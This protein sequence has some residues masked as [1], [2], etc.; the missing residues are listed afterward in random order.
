MKLLN[1]NKVVCLSPHPDDIEASMGGTIL[2]YQD[3]K[4]ISI[5]FST[6]SIHDPTSNEARWEEC[7][8]YWKDTKNI[9]QFFPSP[10]LKM[11]DEEDWIILLQNM[12]IPCDAIF[13]PSNQDTHYEHRFV[14]G[15]GMAMTRNVPISVIEYKSIS[16]LDSWVPNMFVELDEDVETE[17]VTRLKHFKSQKKLYFQRKYMKAF[18]SHPTSIRKRIDITEPF[19]IITLYD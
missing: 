18:H 4:F 1:F 12:V 6:G 14:N 17:K 19:R 10:L 11:Y 2:K 16:T 5:V 13:L 7:K 9:T 3:T 8:Q 15:I